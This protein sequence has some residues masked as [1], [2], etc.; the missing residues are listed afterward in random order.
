MNAADFRKLCQVLCNIDKSELEQAGVV[1]AGQVGGSD[2]H[3]FNSDVTTF[4]LKLPPAR[5][6]AFWT[7][8]EDKLA[9]GK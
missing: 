6:E 4:T 7:L 2:W 9:E 1:R 5:L 3:R 8:I